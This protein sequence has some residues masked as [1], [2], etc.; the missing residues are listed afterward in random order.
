[1]LNCKRKTAGRKKNNKSRHDKKLTI[2]TYAFTVTSR[3]VKSE[4]TT[5]DEV[6]GLVTE[7]ES[8]T[9]TKRTTKSKLKKKGRKEKVK[10]ESKVRARVRTSGCVPAHESTHVQDLGFDVRDVARRH[11]RRVLVRR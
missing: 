8:K 6:N 1:M 3:T 2:Y 4:E 9:K 7:S 5:K 10:E 11:T